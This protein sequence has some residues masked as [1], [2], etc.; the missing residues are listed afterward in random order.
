MPVAD[1]VIAIRQDNDA[2]R[3]YANTDTAAGNLLATEPSAPIFAGAEPNIYVPDAPAM[4]LKWKANASNDFDENA[5]GNCPFIVSSAASPKVITIDLTTWSA[6]TFGA[7]KT[8][9]VAT[10][11]VNYDG[12]TI[13]P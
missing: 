11:I 5:A 6:N 7:T 8:G 1:E 9:D 12:L 3:Y 2:L 10:V 13:T 4:P